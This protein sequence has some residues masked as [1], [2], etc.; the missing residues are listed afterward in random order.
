MVSRGQDFFLFRREKPRAPASKTLT[1][2]KNAYLLKGT[3]IQLFFVIKMHQINQL[4]ARTGPGH[5]TAF[6]EATRM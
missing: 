6:C 3:L 2:A 5:L 4:P 1:D